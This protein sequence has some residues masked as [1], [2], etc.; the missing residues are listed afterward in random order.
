MH[1]MGFDPLSM[2]LN[3][4][5]KDESTVDGCKGLITC[6]GYIEIITDAV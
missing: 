4:H 1:N 6:N 5:H 2:I 3:T